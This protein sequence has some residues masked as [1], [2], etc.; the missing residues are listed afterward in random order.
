MIVKVCLTV[1]F[2]VSANMLTDEFIFW[3]RR[4]NS[5]MAGIC[6]Y[7]LIVLLVW[8]VYYMFYGGV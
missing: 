3:H 8:Y 6:V 5:I 1:I 4:K 7:S 2:I